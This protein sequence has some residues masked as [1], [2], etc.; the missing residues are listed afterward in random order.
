M[1]KLFYLSISLMLLFSCSNSDDS[2][3]NSNNTS[4]N[5]SLPAWLS[6]SYKADNLG[7]VYV[8]TNLFYYPTANPYNLSFL[9]GND[10]IIKGKHNTP[11]ESL[12]SIINEYIATDKLLSVSQSYNTNGSTNY[13]I[14]IELKPVAPATFSEFIMYHISKPSI[15]N[16]IHVTYNNDISSY[17]TIQ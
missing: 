9:T 15:E 7:R 17:Y 11:D 14:K 3:N 2:S 16:K 8:G 13:T 4:T 1:K 12:Q 10:I 6:G 5:I